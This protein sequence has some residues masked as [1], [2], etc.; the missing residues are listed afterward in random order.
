MKIKLHFWGLSLGFLL[1]SGC[2]HAMQ[3]TTLMT[4]SINGPIIVSTTTTATGFQLNLATQD[5][6]PLA[7]YQIKTSV[8]QTSTQTM[9]VIDGISEP[10]VH[11]PSFGPAIGKQS[12]ELNSSSIELIFKNGSK[13]DHYLVQKNGST[14]TIQPIGTPGF[15]KL[16]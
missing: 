2:G 9:I 3:E 13:I 7:N 6:Y 14:L 4:Q 12:I 5:E 1:L 16:N 15:T 10:D 11:V 8:T